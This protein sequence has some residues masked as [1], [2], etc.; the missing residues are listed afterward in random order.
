MKKPRNQGELVQGRTGNND[1]S[2][3]TRP[4]P[5]IQAQSPVF[6][7]IAPSLQGEC[8]KVVV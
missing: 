7:A 3:L 5:D 1:G 2:Y 6:A 8:R 4:T